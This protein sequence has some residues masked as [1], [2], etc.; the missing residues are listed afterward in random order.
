VFESSKRKKYTRN[1]KKRLYLIA[2]MQIGL[3]VP[4]FAQMLAVLSSELFVAPKNSGFIGLVVSML[5]SGTQV[6]GFKPG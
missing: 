2:A 3:P 1:K 4:S 5:A 6:R